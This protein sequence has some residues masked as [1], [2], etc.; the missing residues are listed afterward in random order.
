[1]LIV[2]P[3]HWLTEGGHFLVDNPRLYRRMLRRKMRSEV[4][5][6]RSIY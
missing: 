5:A 2:D 3:W 1:M 6:S 4:P